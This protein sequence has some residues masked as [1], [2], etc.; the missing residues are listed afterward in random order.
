[1][2][3]EEASVRLLETWN[4]TGDNGINCFPYIPTVWKQGYD[5]I[6]LIFMEILC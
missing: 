4:I 1:M 5:D 2:V 3:M 6:V